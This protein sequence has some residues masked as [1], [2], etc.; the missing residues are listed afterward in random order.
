MRELGL[1]EQTETM[2]ALI[3]DDSAAARAQAR[4]ALDQAFGGY[5][6]EVSI[7]E[8]GGGVEAMR[9][10]T[11]SDVDLLLVD[12]HMPGIHGLD[13][14]SFWSERLGRRDGQA[15]IMSTQVSAADRARALQ[16]HAVAGFV[17]KPVTIDALRA[18]VGGFLARDRSRA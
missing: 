10:L 18:V 2:R 15:I 14:L 8:A 4:G 11:S 3:V 12:L 9:V 17:E 6:A 1:L 7:D 16:R 5:G 13:V